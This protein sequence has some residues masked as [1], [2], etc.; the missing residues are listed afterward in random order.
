M[1][2][3][4]VAG[5]GELLWDVFPGGKALGGAP[6]NF[7]YHA[8]QLGLEGYAVSAVG[9][10]AL[11]GEILDT[12]AEKRLGRVVAEVDYPTGTVQVTL[13]DKGVPRYDICQDVAW[14]N[15]PSTPEMEL[16]ARSCRAVCFG[17]LAQRG[18]TSRAT[19]RRFLDLVPGDA[20][21]IYDINLR[22]HYYDS[23]V[24]DESL[25]QCNILKINDE[26]VAIVARLFGLDGLGE[27]EVCLRL[28]REYGLDIVIE[29]K[30]AEGSYVFTADE[31]SWLDTPRV[32]VAD[33]V[34]AGDSF[35]GAF[36][37]ALLNGQSLRE[38][39]R[40]A[41]DVSAYVCT[42]QGAMPGLPA[43]LTGR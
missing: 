18:A 3:K 41:V 15:I 38:A 12:L 1:E 40:L 24:V 9:H 32:Q 8:S 23:R 26:E 31:T 42:Q 14:D 36:T 17:T 21:R 13:D 22:Q 30:G 43:E 10:D 34:G 37:A 27:K 19:I 20:L 7:A 33:T 4:K 16:L 2:S 28:L 11:G 5:I 29:T 6:A 35:T 39:H 25:E